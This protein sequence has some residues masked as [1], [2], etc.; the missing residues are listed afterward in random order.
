M[1]SLN[2]YKIPPHMDWL[3]TSQSSVVKTVPGLSTNHLWYQPPLCEKEH[4]HLAKGKPLPSLQTMARFPGVEDRCSD[5]DAWVRYWGSWLC[6]MLPLEF[7]RKQYTNGDKR[8]KIPSLPLLT[9]QHPADFT[10]CTFT[11]YQVAVSCLQSLILLSAD[12]LSFRRWLRSAI[13]CALLLTL[14]N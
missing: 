14:F 2:I 7:I 4:V 3:H 1:H 10:F 13:H 8:H 6:H 9:R 12:M 5:G 11:T